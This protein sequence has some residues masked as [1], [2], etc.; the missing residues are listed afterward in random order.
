MATILTH[1]VVA[2]TLVAAWPLRERPASVWIAAASLSILP[3]ADVIGFSFGIEYGDLLGH[4]GLS[5]S[6]L[7]ALF[8]GVV[9]AGIFGRAGSR[10]A[11]RASL[12]LLFTFAAASHGVLDALTDGGLGIAFFSP[13]DATRYFFPWR[14]VEVSPIGVSAFFSEWGLAVLESEFVWIWLPCAA[15]SGGFVLARKLRSV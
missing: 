1:P 3:D 13:I 12:A 10:V 15:L 14:P 4:R 8:A 11:N 7:F 2:C 5:H 9:T 6:L